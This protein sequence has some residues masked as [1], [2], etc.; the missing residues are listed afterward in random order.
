MPTETAWSG[1]GTMGASVIAKRDPE[2]ARRGA[3]LHLS[4][5][6]LEQRSGEEG[7]LEGRQGP[8]PTE[9]AVDVLMS[10]SADERRLEPRVP[11][12]LPVG[13]AQP[14]DTVRTFFAIASTSFA[15]GSWYSR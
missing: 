14:E 7:A 10:V 1:R 13:A 3:R 6:V 5:P 2:L 9:Q 12:G 4:F 15:E 11:N 8:R